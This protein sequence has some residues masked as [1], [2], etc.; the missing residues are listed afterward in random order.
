MCLIDFG[1]PVDGG[2]S[3]QLTNEQ[4]RKLRKLQNGKL[5]N[6]QMPEGYD[7]VT[8]TNGQELYAPLKKLQNG[9]LKRKFKVHEV[10]T[11]E[12]GTGNFKFAYFRD[13][14]LFVG[15]LSRNS[16]LIMEKPWKEVVRT[17]DAPVHRHI[18]GT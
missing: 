4:G 14:V 3:A 17:F 18:Y 16:L 8:L 9:R 2:D 15:H 12:G 5:N 11:R 7:E 1:K 6:L 10:E 13:P